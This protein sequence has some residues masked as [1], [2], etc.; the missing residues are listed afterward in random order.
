MNFSF[1]TIMR[2]IMRSHLS[3]T[4]VIAT[5]VLLLTA[6]GCKDSATQPNKD[7]LSSAAYVSFNNAMHGLWADHMQWTYNT[8]D[9]FFN[10]PDG[11]QAQLGRLLHNQQ[12][13]GAAIVP[14]YGQAAG[15]SLASLLTTHINQSVPVLTA[16]KS[17][18]TA[19]L[20]AA[21]KDWYANAN[22]VAMFLST[23]NPQHWDKMELA[24]MM[25][26]HIETTT[27]YAADLLKKD[28]PNAVAH[29][30]EAYTH[31]MELAEQLAQGIALQFP[32]KF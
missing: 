30:D 27:V 28:Y 29:Y 19:A 7:P 2:M 25:E 22:D 6:T 24:H 16:A 26:H 14:Y 23:A 17:G 15:D 3:V 9:A 18:D 11:V 32:D 21:L 5:A 12:D 10:N 31:M 4:V 13:I 8:V 1:L 20:N